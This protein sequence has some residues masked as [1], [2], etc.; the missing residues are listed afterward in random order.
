MARLWPRIAVVLAI[1]LAG[2]CWPT[3]HFAG[4]PGV[5]AMAVAAGA[6]LLGLG[7]G[8]IILARKTQ[9]PGPKLAMTFL[10]TAPIRMTVTLAAAIAAWL[11]GYW[12]V[13]PLM[14][15]TVVFY[16]LLL[17]AEANWLTSL[18]KSQAARSE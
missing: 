9:E 11:A 15:W 5:T 7:A 3:W 17:A 12:P 2:G 6:A 13:L 4:S 10:L 16:L 14:I 8:L 18:L 1:G